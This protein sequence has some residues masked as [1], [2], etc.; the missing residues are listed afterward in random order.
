MGATT[1]GPAQ[2]GKWVTDASGQQRWQGPMIGQGAA[3]HMKPPSVA[4]MA[5]RKPFDAFAASQ[6]KPIEYDPRAASTVGGGGA[7][8]GVGGLGGGIAGG[9]GGVPPS[10]APNLAGPM[11]GLMSAGGGGAGGGG[12]TDILSQ[13]SGPMRANLGQRNYPPLSSLKALQSMRVY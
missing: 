6:I 1:G 13:G 12:E 9:V 2:G 3:R 4:E 8:G 10:V 11:Q 5:G 7:S